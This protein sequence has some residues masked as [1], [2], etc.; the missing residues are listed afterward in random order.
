[1]ADPECPTY[2]YALCL[3]GTVAYP[4]VDSWTTGNLRP[5]DRGRENTR[6]KTIWGLIV[7]SYLSVVYFRGHTQL[8]Y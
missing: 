7:I 2:T 1:M 6:E 8:I 5:V 4:Q 3:K